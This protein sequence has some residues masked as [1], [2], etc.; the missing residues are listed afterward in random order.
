MKL[1][2]IKTIAFILIFGTLL[3]ACDSDEEKFINKSSLEEIIKEAENLIET[4]TEGIEEGDYATGSKAALQT[5]IDWSYY[6]LN[7]SGT[8]TAFSNAI[9]KLGKDIEIYKSNIVKAGY[10]LYGSG[11]FFNLGKL[12]DYNIYEKFTIECKVRFKEYPTSLGNIIAAEDASGGIILRYQ[13]GIVDAYINNGGWLGGSASG[14]PLDLNK[15]YHLAFT[16]S[17]TQVNLYIDGELRLSQNTSTPKPV[18]IGEST[19][20]HIGANPGYAT[21][22]MNGNITNVSIW[23]YARSR[24]E[25]A[26]DLNSSFS[27]TE[28]GLLAYW[29]FDMNLGS[30]I[31]DKTGHFTAQGTLVTW[32]DQ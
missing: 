21:R 10:P 3:W 20:L 15:W 4:T 18:V 14:L 22:I 29:P 17:G 32:E 2:N 30:T 6:I 23:N 5:S 12:S 27:G 25:I 16:F 31:V 13:N 11:S 26:S 9:A 19:N 28:N 8:D 1:F 24:D 7:Y